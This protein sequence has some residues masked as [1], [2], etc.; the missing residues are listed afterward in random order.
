VDVA[1]DIIRKKCRKSRL[2]N[3]I[4]EVDY[5][6][7]GRLNT[8][9]RA[10]HIIVERNEFRLEIQLRSKYQHYW[11]EAVERASIKGQF[12]L[13]E[14]EG[15]RDILKFFQLT[16][17]ALY[18]LEVGKKLLDQEVLELI[19]TRSFIEMTIGNILEPEN[20][21]NNE[22]FINAM[23]EKER[24]LNTKGINNWIIIFNWKDGLFVHWVAPEKKVEEASKQYSD[25]EKTW[26]YEKG[27]EVVL[28]GANSVST[29]RETHSH[30]FGVESYN[31]AL[32]LLK[33]AL[34]EEEDELAN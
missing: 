29:I 2:F 8:G 33:Y 14:G 13:K 32:E 11:A 21:L 16:S 30:Y 15:P 9:Y 10:L 26:P 5:R 31:V 4:H 24:S 6:Q 20:V 17:N 19:N 28:I 1:A 7:N 12:S 27:F 22:Q 34:M 25:L 3:I 18:S 23:I